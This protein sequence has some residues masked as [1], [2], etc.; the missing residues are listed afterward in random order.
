MFFFPT[1]VGNGRTTN[2]NKAESEKPAHICKSLK[3]KKDPF[4]RRRR[5]QKRSDPNRLI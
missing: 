2:T 1:N 4:R 5:C 3:C